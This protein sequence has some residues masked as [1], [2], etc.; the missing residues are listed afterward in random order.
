MKK[1]KNTINEEELNNAIEYKTLEKGGFYSISKKL[2]NIMILMAASLLISGVASYKNLTIK[3]ENAYLSVDDDYKLI[4]KIPLSIPL[5]QDTV[6]N[7]ANEA[8]MKTFSFDMINYQEQIS[9][10]HSNY[11]TDNGSH[12]LDQDF[13]NRNI[14]SLISNGDLHIISAKITENALILRQGVN[15]KGVQ[16]WIVTVP[17]EITT[18][19]KNRINKNN[20]KYKM[21]IERMDMSKRKSGLGIDMIQQN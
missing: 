21:V 10:L 13:K 5:T 14:Y 19:T 18:V 16:N 1:N 3:P 12:S 8:I 15:K 17:V 20:F 9:N 2:N 7:F 11:Y 4:E 6:V